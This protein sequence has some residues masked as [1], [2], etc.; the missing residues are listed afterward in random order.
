MNE[1]LIL[2]SKG[3]L[4]KVSRQL[5]EG[6]IHNGQE[7]GWPFFVGDPEIWKFSDSLLQREGTVLDLGIGA[8]RASMFFALHGMQVRG[9]ERV[10]NPYAQHLTKIAKAYR[11]AISVDFT[12]FNEADFGSNRYDVVMMGQL[13]VH[14]A[15]KQE[16][17]AVLD[18]AIDATKRG[19]YLWLRTSGQEDDNF[20]SFKEAASFDPEV[21]ISEEAYWDWCGC[22]GQPELE[23]HLYLKPTELLAQVLSK[24]M[25]VA[26]SEVMPKIGLKNIMYGE[27]DLAIHPMEPAQKS[28]M[29]T[30]L[31]QKA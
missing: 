20:K 25:R 13:F 31:A 6:M 30:V 19:G 10:G 5:F 17:F 9:I 22:S 11:L 18:R 24:G 4:N 26:H 27:D 28:G 7:K 14:F 2:L 15:E 12:D 3:K 1:K 23:P 21:Q 8:G 29:I 16:A